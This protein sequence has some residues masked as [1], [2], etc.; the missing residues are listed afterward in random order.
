[1][2]YY[3][4]ITVQRRGYHLPGHDRWRR[5]LREIL[6]ESGAQSN[7]FS[8]T[9]GGLS[10]PAAPVILPAAATN[11]TDFTALQASAGATNYFLDVSTG[12]IFIAGNLLINENYDSFFPPPGWDASG[13]E[14]HDLCAFRYEQC[15]ISGNTQW[16]MSR[17]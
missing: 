11:A 1:V 3:L 9:N 13:H 14:R 4:K 10:L 12:S 5:L 8:F 7:A 2:Q 16:L 15:G 17:R 6:V